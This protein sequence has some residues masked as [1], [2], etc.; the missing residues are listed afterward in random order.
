M[1]EY[2][3]FDKDS[4]PTFGRFGMVYGIFGFARILYPSFLQCRKRVAIQGNA[5]LALS[6]SRER[7]GRP[8]LI[9]S[10]KSG[11]RPEREPKLSEHASESDLLSCTT[12]TTLL[13][14]PC[15]S[16]TLLRRLRFRESRPP[17]QSD[18]IGAMMKDSRARNKTK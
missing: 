11:N 1:E 5:A 18:G 15:V 2:I 13:N 8:D 17:Y 14:H 4:P 12:T 16:A 10:R 7:K 3:F 9:I 6:I